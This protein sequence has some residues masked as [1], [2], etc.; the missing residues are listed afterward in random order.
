MC[1]NNRARTINLYLAQITAQ[2]R[3][4]EQ[5]FLL[6]RNYLLVCLLQ[7]LVHPDTINICITCKYTNTNTHTQSIFHMWYSGKQQG[8]NVRL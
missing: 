4:N 8:Q 6:K 7:Y 2:K 3:I 5:S 1:S